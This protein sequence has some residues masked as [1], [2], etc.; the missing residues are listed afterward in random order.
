MWGEPSSS[1]CKKPHNRS[2]N[3]IPK[4]EVQE[5]NGVPSAALYLG[6]GGSLKNWCQNITKH[7]ESFLHLFH[8]LLRKCCGSLRGKHFFHLVHRLLRKCCRSLRGKLRV[9]VDGFLGRRWSSR[10]LS[11]TSRC[12]EPE[13]TPP[14]SLATIR[15]RT[16]VGRNAA[17]PFLSTPITSRRW[18]WDSKYVLGLISQYTSLPIYENQSPNE[19]CV[20]MHVESQTSAFYSFHQMLVSNYSCSILGLILPP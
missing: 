6:G 4:S 17:P 11:H 9:F 3:L 12:K 8:R 7:M 10:V 2:S 19:C 18:T 1:S 15:P 14:S 16:A 20:S 13:W 5:K